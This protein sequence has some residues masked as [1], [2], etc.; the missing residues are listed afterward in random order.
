MRWWRIDLL[1]EFV[2]DD[3]TTHAKLMHQCNARTMSRSYCSCG[4]T[5]SL[6]DVIDPPFIFIQ[7]EVRYLSSCFHKIRKCAFAIRR[8]NKIA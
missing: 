8:K 6:I 7:L 1:V 3:P 5:I 2:L 4:C